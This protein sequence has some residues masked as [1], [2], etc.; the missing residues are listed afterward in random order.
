LAGKTGVSFAKSKRID[1]FKP[2]KYVEDFPSP[3]S[4]CSEIIATKMNTRRASTAGRN[5][6]SLLKLTS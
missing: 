5:Q 3:A 6:A 2:K 4:Y 1:H